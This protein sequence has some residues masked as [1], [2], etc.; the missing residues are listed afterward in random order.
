MLITQ[1]TKNTATLNTNIHQIY[2][3]LNVKLRRLI[4]KAI[5]TPPKILTNLKPFANIHERTQCS[6]L[7]LELNCLSESP[8]SCPSKHL[9]TKHTHTHM[10]LLAIKPLGILW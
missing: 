1:L 2:V 4:P 6:M 8:V 3:L 10:S 5:L 9:L 7:A